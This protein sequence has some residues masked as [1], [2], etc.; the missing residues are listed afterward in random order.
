MRIVPKQYFMVIFSEGRIVSGGK[1]AIATVNMQLRKPVINLL[2]NKLLIPG[3]KHCP[4][5]QILSKYLPQ[6]NSQTDYM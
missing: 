4:N 3:F 5:S 2:G 1:L 6:A